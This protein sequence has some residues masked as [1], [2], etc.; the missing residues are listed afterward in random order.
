MKTKYVQSAS[1]KGLEVPGAVLRPF[2]GEHLMLLRA[3]GKAGA[4]L[5]AHAHPHEQITLVVSGRLRMRVGEEWLELG[6]GDLVHVPSNVE[7]EVVFLEDSVVFDAFHPVRQDLLER[8]EAQ[9]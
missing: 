2:A 7:H 4:P 9:K 3:E 8:L 5:T 1:L 6:A